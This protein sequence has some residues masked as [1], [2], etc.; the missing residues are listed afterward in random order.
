MHFVAD[1]E[2]RRAE[3]AAGDSFVGG[4]FQLFLVGRVFGGGEE[5]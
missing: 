5:V 3:Y 1:E 2:G 4:G